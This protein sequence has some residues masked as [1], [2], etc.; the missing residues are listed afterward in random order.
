MRT[1]LLW[2]SP[3]VVLSLPLA[4]FAQHMAAV[5]AGT[6]PPPLPYPSA[7]SD[8]KPWADIKPGNWRQLNDDLGKP[9]GS[10]GHGTGAASAPDAQARRPGHAMPMP[11][12]EAHQGHQGHRGHPTP[13]AR[14]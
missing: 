9:S 11:M 2:L 5:S 4:A 8:Y 13:G 10:S 14:P 7:F 3:A 1:F 12:S 6:P